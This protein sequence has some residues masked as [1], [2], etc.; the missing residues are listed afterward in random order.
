MTEKRHNGA[1]HKGLPTCV[2]GR[3]SQLEI[4][5]MGNSYSYGLGVVAIVGSPQSAAA[6]CRRG[7][8]SQSIDVIDVLPLVATWRPVRC[9]AGC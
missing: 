1:E 5:V 4:K 3:L 8:R 2:H 7:L 9:L 6:T